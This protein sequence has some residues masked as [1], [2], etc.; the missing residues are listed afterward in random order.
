MIIYMPFTFSRNYISR[1]SHGVLNVLSIRSFE[2]SENDDSVLS[3]ILM[4]ENPDHCHACHR[5]GSCQQNLPRQKVVFWKLRSRSPHHP[6]FLKF[7]YDVWV[8]KWGDFVANE[9]Q[10][11][12]ADPK[13]S[14]RCW[15]AYMKMDA[16]LDGSPWKN[17]F[18]NSGSEKKIPKWVRYRTISN[19]LSM[20]DSW[21]RR[22]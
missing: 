20:K 4:V 3:D 18:V 5:K 8:T 9:N 7:V 22:N 11:C 15:I 19:N 10:T 1:K 6:R 12:T 14:E 21:R 16:P 17:A 13:K 2:I